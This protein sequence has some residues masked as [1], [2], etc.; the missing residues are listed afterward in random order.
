MHLSLSDLRV[1]AAVAE[2]LNLTRAAE[3]C[4]LSLAAVS[5]RIQSIEETVHCRLFEREARGVRLTRA[6]DA[7]A[8]HARAMLLEAD[9]LSI[10]LLH[11]ADGQQG[12]VTI[13]ANTTAVT[14]FMPAVL[15]RFLAT[16]PQLSVSVKELAN[17]D[18]ARGVRDGRC[19][20][21]IV[22]GD[23]DLSGIT[24]MHFAT[25]RLV[26]VAARAHPLAAGGAVPF[27]AVVEHPIISMHEGSTIREFLASRVEAMGQPPLQPR[28]EVNSFESLCL[29]AEAGVGVGVVPESAARRYGGR[30]RIA[31]VPLTDAWA[32]R[33]RYL[34][35]RDGEHAPR[36]LRELMV[37]IC[38]HHETEAFTA[39]HPK[40][41]AA[42]ER[43]ASSSVPP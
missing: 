41:R 15:A 18:I 9:S 11:Y 21:G 38:A 16:H 1:F 14:E 42:V 13:L 34:V 24:S 33:D 22:A 7:F 31:W 2:L 4:H 23:L 5:K 19:G 43:L 40:E 27:S 17:H 26:L 36:Y 32:V 37:A 8:R 20:L 6:G 30:L 10:E 25:D 35:L 3:R 12:H 28:V 39:A 29:M